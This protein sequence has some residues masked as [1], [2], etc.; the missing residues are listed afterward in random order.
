MPPRLTARTC[1][2]YALSHSTNGPSPGAY[3]GQLKG[4][5]VTRR[6]IVVLEDDLDRTLTADETIPFAFDGFAYEVDL[7]TEHA[8]EMRAA[9]EKYRAVAR[10]IG[11]ISGTRV[12]T[13]PPAGHRGPA[14]SPDREQNR[15]IR[16]WALRTKGEGAVSNRGRIPQEIVDEYN[17]S[18]GR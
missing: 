7:T 11:R 10:R 4:T 16:D 17:A 18:A 13:P 2:D 5:T 15:A 8:K 9:I 1:G 14:A 12:T 3:S 6:E